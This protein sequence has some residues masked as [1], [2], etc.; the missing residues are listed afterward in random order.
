MSV[1]LFPIWW[2]E[3]LLDVKLVT[4]GTD[5]KNEEAIQNALYKLNEAY[6]RSQLAA[7]FFAMAGSIPF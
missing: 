3:F 5:L 7:C 6:A 2:S 4:S 1:W